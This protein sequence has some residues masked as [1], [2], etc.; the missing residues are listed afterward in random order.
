MELYKNVIKL[1]LLFKPFAYFESVEMERLIMEYEIG[2]E[3]EVIVWAR[4]WHEQNKD[5]NFRKLFSITFK[6]CHFFE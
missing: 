5:F 1:Q 3:N 4:Q 2:D 6:S